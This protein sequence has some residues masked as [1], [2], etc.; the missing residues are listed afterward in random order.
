M[1]RWFYLS[2]RILWDV[3]SIAE[4]YDFSCTESMEVAPRTRPIPFRPVLLT[5]PYFDWVESIKLVHDQPPCRIALPVEGS[6]GLV[7]P[8]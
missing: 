1:V 2:G 4:E 6:E 3:G 8:D 5:R 7:E